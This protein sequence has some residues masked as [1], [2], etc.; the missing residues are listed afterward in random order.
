SWQHDAT[1]TKRMEADV[2]AV[3]DPNTGVAVYGPTSARKSGWLVFG[4]TSVAAP[5]VA[6][7][8]GVNGGSVNYGSDPYNN[9]GALY[10]VTSGNNGSCGGTYYCTA[11]VGYDGPT[12]LGTPNGSAAF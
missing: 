2:S 5:L 12:G 1:C 10:D 6:G 7:V 8:Y 3:A 11:K 4:G 9:T